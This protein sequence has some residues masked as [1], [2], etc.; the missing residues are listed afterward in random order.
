MKNK[1]LISIAM[2]LLLLGCSKENIETTP[3]PNS[4]ALTASAKLLEENVNPPY[5]PEQGLSLLNK[6]YNDSATACKPGDSGYNRVRQCS[7][8]IDRQTGW[9][10]MIASRENFPAL[11]NIWNEI[12]LNN[13][14]DGGQMPNISQRSFSMSIKPEAFK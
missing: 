5:P 3:T 2:G 12:L 9:N 4:V 11:N 1:H 14:D 7:W 13:Y 10:N 8:N 6:N